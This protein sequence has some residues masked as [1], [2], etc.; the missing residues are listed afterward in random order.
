MFSRQ[1]AEKVHTYMHTRTYMSLLAFVR[2]RECVCVC[3]CMALPL[4]FINRAAQSMLLLVLNLPLPSDERS[5][6]SWVAI[7]TVY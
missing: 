7:S 2:V 5:L 3:L 6:S 1:L 4:A